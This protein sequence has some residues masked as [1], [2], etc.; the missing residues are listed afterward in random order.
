LQLNAD[1]K[2]LEQ[3]L[4]NLFRN[5]IQALADTTDKQ[6]K[7][8]VTRINETISISVAD[9]GKGIPQDIIETIFVP[10]FTTKTNGS[11]IGLT[12]SREIM[13]LHGG[14]IKV[15]SELGKETVF[16]LVF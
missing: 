7:V 3:V 9:N 8:T 12:L 10:F 11:G 6:L 14:Y 1:E 4:I 5:A 2:L 15:S 16:T 13:K